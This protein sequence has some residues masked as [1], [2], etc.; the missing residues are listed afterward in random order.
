MEELSEV[1]KE[2][3]GIAI[4]QEEQQYQNN[5]Q[6]KEYNGGA[7]DSSY[8]YSKGFPYLASMEREALGP[9]EAQYPNIRGC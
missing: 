7:H 2:F 3:K 6:T 1:L 5:S 4:P 9:E 8:M